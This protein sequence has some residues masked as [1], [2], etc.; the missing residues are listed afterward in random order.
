MTHTFNR[1]A[2][3]SLAAV[4]L[5]AAAPATAGASDGRAALELVPDW[6]GSIVVL[7]AEHMRRSSMFDDLMTLVEKS[8]AMRADARLLRDAGFDLRRD[9]KTVVLASQPE[10]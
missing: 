4:L 9:L 1:V 10:D 3:I 2:S 8:G 5:A 6:A 7:N